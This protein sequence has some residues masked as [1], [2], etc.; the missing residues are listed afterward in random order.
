MAAKAPQT[1]PCECSRWAILVDDTERTDL[2]C[3]ATTAGRF[4]PGHDAKLKGMLVRANIAGQALVRTDD[5][6]QTDKMDVAQ[7]LTNHF[8][9]WTTRVNK[10][11]T[12]A[13]AD[14]DR[15]QRR[16]AA[17][18]NRPTR[19]RTRPE[20]VEPRACSC[21][22]R[23]MPG[24]EVCAACRLSDSLANLAARHCA[25]DIA[26]G[27]QPEPL[28]DGTPISNRQ[29]VVGIQKIEIPEA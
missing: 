1:H 18:A 24:S 10:S 27:V 8:P 19:V 4:A 11:T 5:Q 23:A 9:K 3:T 17:R 2:G 29:R 7:A 15:K 13:T 14:A 20:P 25:T 12:S 26:Q 22:Q 16:A 6:G 28:P 21:G